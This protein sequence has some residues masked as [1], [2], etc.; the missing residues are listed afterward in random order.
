MR[1]MNPRCAIEF[2]VVS[3]LRSGD[4]EVELSLFYGEGRDRGRWPDPGTDEAVAEFMRAA[5]LARRG[6]DG[7]PDVRALSSSEIDAYLERMQQPYEF[8]FEITFWNSE[9]T[10]QW[11]R[12]ELFVYEPPTNTAF[13]RHSGR[14][15]LIT[16]S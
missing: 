15:V 10:Q 1:L 4:K 6:P 2:P 9:H 16:P 8:S 14:P 3:D 11:R 7:E 13:I 5:R 12:T